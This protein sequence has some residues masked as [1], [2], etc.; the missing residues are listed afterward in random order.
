MRVVFCAR[1]PEGS[2]AHWIPKPRPACLLGPPP[3]AAGAAGHAPRR[4]TPRPRGARAGGAA[5]SA[6]PRNPHCRSSLVPTPPTCLPAGCPRVGP[7]PN[8][9]CTPF[10]NPLIANARRAPLPGARRR[11]GLGRGG[12][13]REH[14]RPR[15][16]RRPPPPR[17]RPSWLFTP[18]RPGGIP[19]AV[20][21]ARAPVAQPPLPPPAAVPGG[22]GGS[23]GGG[24]GARRAREASP[25]PGSPPRCR[26]AAKAAAPLSPKRS[27]A[28]CAWP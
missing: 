24:G 26:A 13:R 15:P 25:L 19:T 27:S 10:A 16:R 9:T 11:R 1:S 4:R 22:G 28:P 21:P 7:P 12:G 5:P 2:T 14:N 6:T 23:G 17:P 18:R 20:R 3:A 8:W